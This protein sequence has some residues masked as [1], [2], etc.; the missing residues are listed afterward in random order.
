[1]IGNPPWVSF[2]DMSEDY[3]QRFREECQAARLWIGGKIAARQNLSACF[4]MRA[5]LL[6]MRREERVGLVLPYAAMSRQAYA[7][8]RKGDW[9]QAKEP[10]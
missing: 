3:R 4:F 7:R 5:A 9:A 1:M 8:V 10:N 2:R 6:Y